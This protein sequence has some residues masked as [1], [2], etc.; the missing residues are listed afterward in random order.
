[1]KRETIFD[2][3]VFTETSWECSKCGCV[4][5]DKSH[6]PTIY[7]RFEPVE[8]RSGGISH[9][10]WRRTGMLCDELVAWKVTNL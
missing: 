4:V 2:G 5:K 1:M 6:K 8:L 3:L 10:A 9:F 7:A